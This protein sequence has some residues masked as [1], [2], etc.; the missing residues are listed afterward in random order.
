[1]ESFRRAL[2]RPADYA[3]MSNRNVIVVRLCDRDGGDPNAP[4]WSRAASFG[5]RH[6]PG[7]TPVAQ[8][9]RERPPGAAIGWPRARRRAPARALAGYRAMPGTIG[10]S[11]YLRV[12]ASLRRIATQRPIRGGTK[13][14]GRAAGYLA[15]WG[16]RVGAPLVARG[17]RSSRA[18]GRRVAQPSRARVSS[19]GPKPTD[20]GSEREPACV[21]PRARGG[22]G[23]SPRPARRV[24]PRDR[25]R[26]G[27]DE[28]QPRAR[29]ARDPL[30]RGR[31]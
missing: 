18:A 7:P 28:A 24:P 27:L 10:C 19:R 25:A 23:L 26:R 4:Q 20:P 15:E 21:A 5:G 11:M 30:H 12:N 29:A 17:P 13:R 31:L 2:E 1:M 3:P 8:R 9:P 16:R 22:G 6:P 14:D